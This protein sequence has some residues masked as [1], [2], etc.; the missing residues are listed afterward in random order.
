MLGHEVKFGYCRQSGGSEGDT[1]PCRKIFDCWFEIFDI[2]SFMREHY[3][4]AE[5]AE[6][7]SPQK[8]KMVSL[9][10]LIRRAQENI[11]KDS[12]SKS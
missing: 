10:E 5:I 6:V 3:S 9:M 7:L 4:E 1:L 8:D 12:N 2:E 11:K